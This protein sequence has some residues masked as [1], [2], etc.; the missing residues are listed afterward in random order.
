MIRT[1]RAVHVLA[2]AFVLGCLPATALA[3]VFIGGAKPRPGTFESTGGGTWTGGKTFPSSAATLTPNPSGGLS[4]FELFNTEPR[5]EP[6]FGVH[7]LLGVYVTR[8]LSIEGGLHFSRPN[9][10]FRLEDDAEDAPDVTATTTIT[11]YVFTGSLVYHFTTTGRTVPFIA[12][13]AGH[14][15]DVHA[16]NE[17][18]ETGLE[19]HAKAGIKSW[20]GRVRKFGLRA[21][22][23][24]SV[25]DG[26]FSYEDDVRMAPGAAVSLLYLF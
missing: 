25:R 1:S 10:E 5:L 13:G 23:T 11:S 20:F 17:I 3:Q 21:E 7:G 19:Y 16:G 2:L 6:V 22:A 9:L 24:L 8:S 18:V 12:G 14:I 15:R 4:S 26:G